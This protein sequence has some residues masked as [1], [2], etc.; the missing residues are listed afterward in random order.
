MQDRDHADYVLMDANFKIQSKL[1]FPA[2]ETIFN[3]E[4]SNLNNIKYVG[5]T[6][7]G[8]LYNFVFLR[9]KSKMFSN[10]EYYTYE[11]ETVDFADKKLTHRELIKIPKADK[12]ISAFSEHNHFTIISAMDDEEALK[13]YRMKDDGSVT[14]KTVSFTIPETAN[15]Q[16]KL[17]EYL[18]DA[19]VINAGN[20]AGLDDAASSTKIYTSKEQITFLIN[21]NGNTHKADI[22]FTD[23]SIKSIEIPA[24]QLNDSKN[25]KTT[26]NSFINGSNIFIMNIS[27]ADI[28]LLVY[29][30]SKKLLNSITIDENNYESFVKS[31][32]EYEEHAGKKDKEKVYE[33]FAELMKGLN[34]GTVGLTASEWNDKIFITIGT[35]DDIRVESGGAG[36]YRSGIGYGSA[37]LPSQQL[38]SNSYAYSYYVPGSSKYISKPNYFKSSYLKLLL[39]KTSFK[40]EKSKLPESTAKQIR[41]FLLDAEQKFPNQFA[42]NNKQY[43]GYYEANGETYYFQEIAIKK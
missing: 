12:I 37:S 38:T 11:V 4:A 43:Y 33:S 31:P 8:N 29:D 41:T 21:K 24:E 26:I 32:G 20:D 17:S 5:G 42:Y 34:K 6:N 18:G 22:S 28:K 36:S 7:K 39:N 14:E 16:K 19:V 35:Y 40:P 13:I 10:K 23:Y 25:K 27:N 15:K 9:S 30:F 2:S 3:F 1:S